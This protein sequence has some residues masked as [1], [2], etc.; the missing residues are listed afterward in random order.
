MTCKFAIA[1]LTVS[2]FLITCSEEESA[3]LNSESRDTDTTT[4]LQADTMPAAVSKPD[5]MMIC[6][7]Y[8]NGD[9]HNWMEMTRIGDT[10]YG[11][12]HYTWGGKDGAN[13]PFHGKFSGDTLWILFK[14]YGEGEYIDLERA[15]LLSG[16][17]LL[18]GQ[19]MQESN[20]AGNYYY[21]KHK[22]MIEFSQ[23]EYLAKGPCM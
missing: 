17:K 20:D 11:E 5:T 16:D 8:D 12:L 14:S 4:A 18:E 2:L 13:G 10:A 1:F 19:G 6:Y 9:Q 22:K 3:R 15:Y 21:F 23:K 7:R